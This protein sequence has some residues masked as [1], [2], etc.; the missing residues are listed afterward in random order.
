MCMNLAIDEF[1]TGI[2]WLCMANLF[3]P[4]LWGYVQILLSISTVSNEGFDKYRL[5]ITRAKAN[6]PIVIEGMANL[7]PLNLV[8]FCA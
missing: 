6:N 4:N 3:L 1:D 7:S 8:R 2:S 5:H